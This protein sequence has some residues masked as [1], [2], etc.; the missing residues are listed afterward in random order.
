M[1][2][3][4]T[5][6]N[7]ILKENCGKGFSCWRSLKKYESLLKTANKAMGKE[8]HH[9]IFPFTRK[10]P[11]LFLL[12]PSL[13]YK[14]RGAVCELKEY[15][16]PFSIMCYKLTYQKKRFHCLDLAFSLYYHYQIIS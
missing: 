13:F 15:S 2:L 9:L 1:I 8:K 4:G 11:I 12:F 7:R 6:M 16:S 14:S 3:A 10:E 5:L